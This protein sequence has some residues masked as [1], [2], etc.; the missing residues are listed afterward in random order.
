MSR[1]GDDSPQLTDSKPVLDAAYKVLGPRTTAPAGPSLPTVISIF[2]GFMSTNILSSSLIRL[3]PQYL[4]PV[5]G[6]VLP[7]LNYFYG[8]L[9]SFILGGLMGS[10]YWRYILSAMSPV[11]KRK[12]DQLTIDTK[13]T[14]AIAMAFDMAAILTALAPTRASYLFRYSDMVSPMWGPMIVYCLFTFPAFVLGGFV[15]VLSAARVSYNPQSKILQGAISIAYLS[16]VAMSVW[17]GHTFAR[18]QVACTGILFNAIFAGLSSVI[19]KLL[20]GYQETVDSA[21]ALEALKAASPDG[22][23]EKGAEELTANLRDRQIRK[24]Q[25]L[26]AGGVLFFALTTFFSQP[27]CTNGLTAA[28]NRNTTQYHMLSRH[29]S[30]TGWVSVS[31]EA[32]RGIR[33]LRSGHSIL[34]GQWNT[35]NE[36]I[37]GDNKHH[38]ASKSKGM[39]RALQIGLGIGV[40]ARSLHEQNVRVDVVEIDPEVYK[41]AVDYFMLPKNLNGVYLQD[42]RTFIDESPDHTYDYI[43]H[44]VFTGGSL[45]RI[46]KPNGTLAMNYVGIMSDTRSLYH[47]ARTISTVF[48]H[49]RCFA[50]S[51]D[52]M[53]GLT[54]MMF[55][56]SNSPLEFDISHKVL[57]AMDQYTI[58]SNMLSKMEE[59]EI[60][61]DAAYADDVKPITD[62][63]NPL[64][65]WQVGSAIAH[66]KAMRDLFPT[67]YWLNY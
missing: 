45:E 26:P 13:T 31:D 27:S 54:N 19:I 21:D 60:N 16:A 47:V 61:I 3:G 29:E 6:N 37:F 41:A 39:M 9:F 22:K 63:W 23:L 11:K 50:E 8:I 34:G 66:W 24:L 33:L 18:P 7:Y 40:S 44:D 20:T 17:L 57:R 2:I 14:R 12:G 25:F 65:Q 28:N 56:A 1:K 38:P 59:R 62:Q 49:V 30:I 4:E 10:S 43:V 48:S 36:S 42:G 51:L 58:R 32:Q 52:D 67:E 46:L 35:T 5:F 64:P 15:A 53:D 55:F